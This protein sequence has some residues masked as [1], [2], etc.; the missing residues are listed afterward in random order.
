MGTVLGGGP[1]EGYEQATQPRAFD[2]PADH[3]PHPGFRNEWWYVTGNLA[4][5]DPGEAYGF[6][7]TFF[8]ISLAPPGVMPSGRQSRWA[9]D[10][11]YMAHFALTDID[12]GSFHAFE[13]FRRPVLGLA[14]AQAKPFR[15]WLDDWSLEG[16]EEAAGSDLW[17]LRIRARQGGAGIRLQLSDLKGR[18]LQ[19]DRGYSPKGEEPG[20]ASFYYSYP[21]L[22]ARGTVTVDGRSRPVTGTAWLDREWSTSALGRD[23]AGWDWFSLQ[24]DDG[25]ELMLYQLRRRDG[26]PDPSSDATLIAADGSSRRLGREEISLEVQDR[27]RAADGV[28]YPAR[29]R[30]RLPGEN[31]DVFVTPRLENQELRLTVRY[32][33]GTV[34]V[35]GTSD[36]EPV[37]GA[38][39]AELTGYDG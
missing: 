6:Q 35:Q 38:G 18:I 27:W 32:W 25:R 33:E 26:S 9:T 21:R 11:L 7:L 22:Q 14:G 39:Y 29:W 1:A 5:Q 37:S 23:V 4:G 8:R 17:P 16:P 19:G 24:L 30:L 28:T 34:E 13:R 3:G 20:N 10:Q 36:G 12:G 2:F 15:V 31:L